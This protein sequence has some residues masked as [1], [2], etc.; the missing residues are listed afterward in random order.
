MFDTVKRRGEGELVAKIQVFHVCMIIYVLLPYASYE[1]RENPKFL[2]HKVKGPRASC[3]HFYFERV[4]VSKYIFKKIWQPFLDTVLGGNKKKI[5]NC[6]FS[7]V[8]FSSFLVPLVTKLK[9]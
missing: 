1:Q 5:L 6:V 3:I 7:F 2:K 9:N 4:E 8:S